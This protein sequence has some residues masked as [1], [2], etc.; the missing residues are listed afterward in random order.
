MENLRLP[1]TLLGVDV[2][3]NK[4]L[5]L[6]DVAEK[7]LLEITKGNN[8]KLVITPIGGQGYLFGR[9]NQ[10]ISP[11]VLKNIGKKNIIVIATK[12]NI[13]ELHGSPFLVDTGDEE[14]DKMFNGYVR[15]V[16]GYR[17]AMIYPIKS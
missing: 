14:T 13:S 8:C 6:S 5:I 17:E 4:K 9:G 7:Q 10:Q 3:M 2:V 11:K 12:Q 15:V 16:T 1:Y